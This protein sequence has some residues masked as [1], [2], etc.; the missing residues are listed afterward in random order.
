MGDKK[1]K[2][3]IWDRIFFFY[4]S[5]KSPMQ[6]IV[7][8]FILLIISIL[9]FIQIFIFIYAFVCLFRGSENTR[10]YMAAIINFVPCIGGIIARFMIDDG[11]NGILTWVLYLIPI[12]HIPPFSVVSSMF[13]LNNNR[14]CS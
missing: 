11:W 6:I 7:A 10:H 14:F 12:F 5:D 1:D 8:L 13:I 4:N 3:S 9:F 2:K